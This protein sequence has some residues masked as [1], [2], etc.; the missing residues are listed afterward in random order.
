MRTLGLR[1]IDRRSPHTWTKGV[2]PSPLCDISTGG[3]Y[4][5]CFASH[6]RN[7]SKTG[8]LYLDDNDVLLYFKQRTLENHDAFLP[9]YSKHLDNSG[10]PFT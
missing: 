8:I 7:E 5:S 10:I 6:V 3:Q 1:L 2:T 4:S 9:G